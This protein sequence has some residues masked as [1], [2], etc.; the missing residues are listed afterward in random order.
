MTERGHYEVVKAIKQIWCLQDLSAV[1]G[2]TCT[3]LKGDGLSPGTCPGSILDEK[4]SLVRIP[5]SHQTDI[6]P[7]WIALR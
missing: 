3:A 6:V 7:C 4:R 5:V 2:C 1:C